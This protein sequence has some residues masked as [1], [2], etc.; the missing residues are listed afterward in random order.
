MFKSIQDD[1]IAEQV[2]AKYIDCFTYSDNKQL[3]SSLEQPPNGLFE[4]L[5]DSCSLG[6][7]DDESFLNKLT[8]IAA[9]DKSFSFDKKS[10][11][12]FIVNHTARP[13]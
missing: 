5:N 2:E 1:L 9:K 11:M 7:D 4:I 8:K 12:T 3:I 13:V 10:K 6:R